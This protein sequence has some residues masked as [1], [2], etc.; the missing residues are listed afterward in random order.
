MAISSKMC[1]GGN[2]ALLNYSNKETLLI[3]LKGCKNVYQKSDPYVHA[4]DPK[5]SKNGL[6][7]YVSIL[8]AS[9]NATILL[10]QIRHRIIRFCSN[11]NWTIYNNIVEDNSLI[12]KF[13]D[14]SFKWCVRKE[15]SCERTEGFLNIGKISISRRAPY[16]VDQLYQKTPIPQTAKHYSLLDQPSFTWLGDEEQ[17]PL[18]YKTG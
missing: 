4:H 5:V 13:G 10:V 16:N 3:T 2:I 17:V 18:L 14:I 9:R 6:T 1:L 8:I 11:V 7:L 12:K 15:V